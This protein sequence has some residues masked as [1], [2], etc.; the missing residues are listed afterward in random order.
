MSDYNMNGY[1]L[2]ITIAMQAKKGVFERLKDPNDFIVVLLY[3]V[4]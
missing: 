2:R 3:W 1:I 4:V